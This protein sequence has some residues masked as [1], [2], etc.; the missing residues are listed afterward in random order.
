MI[1]KMTAFKAGKRTRTG[2]ALAE[3][4]RTRR[5]ENVTA[6]ATAAVPG[7]ACSDK[8]YEACV[9]VIKGAL[10]VR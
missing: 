9:R 8:P 2:R 3:V 6:A 10:V 1:P 5:A 7:V 4:A